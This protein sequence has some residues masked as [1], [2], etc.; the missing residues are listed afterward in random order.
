LEKIVKLVLTDKEFLISNGCL[1]PTLK[2]VRNV[3][4]KMFEKEI[5][6]IYK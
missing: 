1:T 3:I 6:A 5:E 4:A 2:L